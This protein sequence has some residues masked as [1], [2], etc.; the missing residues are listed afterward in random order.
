MSRLVENSV[1][2]GST[3]SFNW[4]CPAG[5]TE[6]LIQPTDSNGV[7]TSIPNPLTVVPNTTYSVTINS[8]S[9]VFGTQNTFGALYSWAGGG[10][11]KIIFVE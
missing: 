6:I 10:F 11:V 7:A 8:S 1:G 3:G 5:V 4:V 9:Y 2:N